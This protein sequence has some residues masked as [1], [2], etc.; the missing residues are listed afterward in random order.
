[1]FYQYLYRCTS[2]TPVSL[3]YCRSKALSVGTGGL[4]SP[5]WDCGR[6]F[7]WRRLMS[8]SSS[9]CPLFLCTVRPNKS[10][11]PTLKTAD[12]REQ[13]R[14]LFYHNIHNLSCCFHYLVLLAVVC[15]VFLYKAYIICVQ[16]SASLSGGFRFSFLSMRFRQPTAKSRSPYLS[17]IQSRPSRRS[18]YQGRPRTASPYTS[19]RY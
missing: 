3:F 1:M 16:T 19:T 14:M 17:W 11:P 18:F 15:P 6:E 7:D 4:R 10:L 12:D 9:R 2:N 8:C 5:R 13:I